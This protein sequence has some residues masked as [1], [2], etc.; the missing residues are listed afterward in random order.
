V[1]VRGAVPTAWLL[2]AAC[3]GPVRYEGLQPVDHPGA[4]NRPFPE[5]RWTCRRPED[6]DDLVYDLRIYE[7]ETGRRVYEREGLSG[8]THRV[9]TPLPWREDLHWSV[10]ARYRRRGEPR[11]TAWTAPLGVDRNGDTSPHRIV[12]GIPLLVK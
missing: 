1:N 4:S 11:R 9:E 2:A 12:D 6:V 5:L 8:C 7:R 10:R 3:T